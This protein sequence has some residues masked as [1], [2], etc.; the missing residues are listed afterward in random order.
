MTQLQAAKK[1]KTTKEMKR[2]VREENI[3]I[4]V[5][6]KKIADGLI[7]IPANVNHKKL[8]PIGIGYGLKIKVNAN[9][10]TSPV[11][12]DLRIELEN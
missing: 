6:K 3:S 5:L 8:K 12:S 1:N 4:A 10:G 11:K 9:I 2:V 7:V